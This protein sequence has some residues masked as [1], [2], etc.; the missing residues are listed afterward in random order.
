MNRPAPRISVIVP[1]YN[2]VENIGGALECLLSQSTEH[3]YEIIVV[4]SSQDG[5]A[6]IVKKHAPRVR[7][8]YSPERLS[9]GEARNRGLAIARG[10]KILFTDADARVPPRWIDTLARHLETY[11]FTGGAVESAVPSNIGPRVSDLLEFIRCLPAKRRG[12]R[13]N[14][15]YLPGVN[16]GYR[17]TALGKRRFLSCRAQ[18]LILNHEL[19]RDGKTSFF[20]G[21]L[22]V[23]HLNKGSFERLITFQAKLGRSGYRWRL[24]SNKH[25]FV[26]RNPGVMLLAPFAKL[27]YLLAHFSSQRDWSNLAFCIAASPLLIVADGCWAYG[28]ISAARSGNEIKGPD[29]E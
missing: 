20:D 19:I 8:E 2:E 7:L 15:P 27:V 23:K 14:S 16:C 5:T 1:S 21:S 26:T 17:R 3:D 24:L 12:S 25:F 18:D 22:V 10:E 29:P 13:T 28:F 4:D 11:D 9:C 6:E